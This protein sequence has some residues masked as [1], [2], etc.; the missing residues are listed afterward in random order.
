MMESMAQADLPKEASKF[1]R[2][3]CRPQLLFSNKMTHFYRM[4]DGLL[5]K[6][7]CPYKKCDASV[8]CS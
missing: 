8:R 7:Y 1:A 2:V 3:N 5:K 4:N 6:I